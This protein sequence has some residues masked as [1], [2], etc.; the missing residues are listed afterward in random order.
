LSAKKLNPEEVAPLVTGI[1]ATVGLFRPQPLQAAW[2]I[3]DEDA[4]LIAEPLARIVSRMSPGA[5]N[6]VRKFADPVSLV[7]ASYIVYKKCTD[8]EAEI[9]AS[10]KLELRQSEVRHNEASQQ[11]EVTPATKLEFYQKYQQ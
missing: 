2:H 9:I 8:R 10:L 7:F 6:A 3:D 5:V 4:Q 11:E 1:F